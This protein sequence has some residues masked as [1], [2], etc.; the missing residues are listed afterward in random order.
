MTIGFLALLAGLFGV[1]IVLLIVGHRL[2]RRPPRTRAMFRGAAFGHCVAMIIAVTWGMI[3]AEMWQPE[4]LGRGLA[5]FWSL[6]VLPIAGAL[7]ARF[8][9]RGR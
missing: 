2:R 5:G 9:V 3:P 1:P 8:M 4:D 7:V 6:L